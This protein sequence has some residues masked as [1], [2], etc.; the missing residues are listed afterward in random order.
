MSRVR[1]ATVSDLLG[2]ANLAARLVQH[3]HE[4]DPARF[5]QFGA[6]DEVRAGYQR[7]LASE[8]G[9]KDVVVFVAEAD[10]GSIVGYTYARIE[11]RNW[12]ML[13]DRHGAI[14][15]IYVEENARGAGL[16]RELML[17][18]IR[19]LEERGVPRVVLH[20]AA[21]NVAAQ[22]L[23]TS[24]GFRTTMLEMTHESNS[25]SKSS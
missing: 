2:V 8:L 9:S 18:T 25:S 5:M 22:R 16:A 12:N 11:P 19:V 6:L 20:T 7:F 21:Q 24:L 10:D 4:L 3:H 13:L 15:D 23:F 1:E 17:E 14:H